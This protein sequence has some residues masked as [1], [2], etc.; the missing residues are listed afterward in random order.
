MARTYPDQ[1]SLVMAKKLIIYL[2]KNHFGHLHLQCLGISEEFKSH[3][4]AILENGSILEFKWPVTELMKYKISIG[5]KLHACIIKW[6]IRFSALL[7]LSKSMAKLPIKFTGFQRF[8]CDVDTAKKNI[9]FVQWNCSNKTK[10]DCRNFLNCT[11]RSLLLLLFHVYG[12]LIFSNR[13]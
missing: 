13:E 10:R 5:A 2:N 1:V 8:Q 3:P 9:G 12:V 7:Q 4:A 6:T 11:S